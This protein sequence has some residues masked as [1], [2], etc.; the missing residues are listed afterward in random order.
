MTAPGER[1]ECDICHGK[2]WWT[3][4]EG[5]EIPCDLCVAAGKRVAALE[6]VARLALLYHNDSHRADTGFR[7][8]DLAAC[9]SSVCKEVVA[10]APPAP[11]G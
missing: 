10:L 6:A 1:T 4:K 7:R 11:K 3:S 9:V 5:A 2:G 8:D